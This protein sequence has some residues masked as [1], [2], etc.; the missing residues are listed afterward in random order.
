MNQEKIDV[1]VAN[2]SIDQV[3][4]KQSKLTIS[5]DFI[6]RYD[7]TKFDISFKRQLKRYAIGTFKEVLE[8]NKNFIIFTYACGIRLTKKNDID[9]EEVSEDTT[10]SSDEQNTQ[11]SNV[12]LQLESEFSCYY[13]LKDHDIDEDCVNEFGTHNVP[14]HVWP[15]WREHVQST[16][17]KAGIEN[18]SMPFYS[19]A[20]KK[21]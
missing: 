10:S 4:L 19:L 15:Y 7:K 5:D 12:Y 11:S 14:Y 21:K 9:A 13:W 16:L 8:G 20:A 3:L 6:P 1:A 17:A 18:V 2:L